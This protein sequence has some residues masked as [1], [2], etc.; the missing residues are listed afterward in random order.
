MG[1]GSRQW[2]RPAPGTSDG[3]DRGFIYAE[4]CRAFQSISIHPI[5]IEEIRFIDI[6]QFYSVLCI[7]GAIVF[8]I[9]LSTAE[10][11]NPGL[12]TWRVDKAT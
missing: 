9:L 7:K 1:R 12:G 5:E 11:I 4:S 8:C 10:D 2:G 6:V 3:E